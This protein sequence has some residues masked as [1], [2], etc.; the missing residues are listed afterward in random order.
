MQKTTENLRAENVQLRKQVRLLETNYKIL[1]EVWY[2]FHGFIP[3]Y[4]G[5]GEPRWG[6]KS[7]RL[8][9]LLTKAYNIIKPEIDHHNTGGSH[10]SHR[11]NN[12]DKKMGAD[13]IPK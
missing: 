8:Q 11:T 7:K 10:G 5:P 3:R 4:G 2:H 1:Y 12:A 9:R 13:R 6:I